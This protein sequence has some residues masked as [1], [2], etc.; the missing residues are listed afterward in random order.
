[1]NEH[2]LR[3][4]EKAHTEKATFLDLGNCGLTAIPEEILV[5]A[6]HL[7]EINLGMGYY[8]KYGKSLLSRNGL[9]LNNFSTNPTSLSIL[10]KFPDLH[11]LFL[12]RCGIEET[13]AKSIGTLSHLT[14]LGIGHNDIGEKGADSVS[15]LSQLK[16]LDICFNNIGDKGADSISNLANLNY[17]ESVRNV[18][19]FEKNI[20]HG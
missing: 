18:T 16:K 3:L 6:S 9:S 17:L 4:I 19:F 11:S 2:V 5:C 1:M 20:Y 14:I 12:Q 15:N 7:K 10:T 8:F 13:G